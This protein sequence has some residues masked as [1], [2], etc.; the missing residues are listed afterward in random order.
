MASK[1]VKSLKM[2]VGYVSVSEAVIISMVKK[3]KNLCLSQFMA[4]LGI[5]LLS[6]IEKETGVKLI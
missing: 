1:F 2:K 3:G 5:G 6:K 4:D